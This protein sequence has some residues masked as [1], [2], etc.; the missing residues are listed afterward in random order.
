MPRPQKG[1]SKSDFMERCVPEIIAEG[2]KQDQAVAICNSLYERKSHSVKISEKMWNV[3]K[4]ILSK[5]D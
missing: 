5:K 2:K 3:F 1:E 4:K